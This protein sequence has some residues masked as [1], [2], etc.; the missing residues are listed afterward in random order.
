L[1]VHQ[2]LE[3]FGCR[4]IENAYGVELHSLISHP[5]TSL[6]GKE[7]VKKVLSNSSF[8]ISHL[9]SSR[10]ITSY[11]VKAG[12]SLCFRYFLFLISYSLFTT[13]APARLPLHP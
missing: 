11:L 3:K 9:L 5:P 10:C 8:F 6:L 1:L 12:S 13:G 2:L 7:G 4:R